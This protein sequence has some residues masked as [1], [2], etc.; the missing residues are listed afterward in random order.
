MTSSNNEALTVLTSMG[1]DLSQAQSALDI[2]NGDVNNA[3]NFLLNEGAAGG[4]SSAID[5]SN[6][7]SVIAPEASHINQVEQIQGS[8][9]QYTYEYG[10][11]ACSFI[12]LSAATSILQN[13]A[14]G[15]SM[16]ESLIDDAV[17]NGCNTYSEWK[18]MNHSNESIE[19]TSAEEILLCGYFSSLELR[20]GGIRQGMLSNNHHSPS[21]LPKILMTCQSST[22]WVCVVMIKPPETVLLCLP[23]TTD[24]NENKYYLFDSHPRMMEF[25]SEHAYCRI[26]MSLTDLVQSV[27]AIFPI[28]DLG[29]DVPEYMSSMYNSFDL[30]PV[31][32]VAGK[33]E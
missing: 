12:A 3:A 18:K 11:S 22:D 14:G 27:S 2:A 4:V 23:P 1:F 9:S 20:P 33:D 28:A 26:H 10:R 31:Q 7:N 6:G 21:S 32:H 13:T 30:Y 19:H 29:P 15:V 17:Q 16:T 24:N 25:G 5:E 8:K